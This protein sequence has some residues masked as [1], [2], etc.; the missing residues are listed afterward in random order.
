MAL[1]KRKDS[2]YWWMTLDGQG[3]TINGRHRPLKESTGIR[4]DGAS[5]EIRKRLEAQAQEVYHARMVQFARQRVGLPLDTGVTF[6]EWSRWYEDHHTNTHGGAERERVIL[7]HLRDYFGGMPLKAIRPARW[8]EYKT[9]R[10]RVGAAINTIGRELA[11]M[12][13]ILVTAVGE[14]IEVSPLAHVKRKTQRLPPKRTITAKEEQHL[15]FELSDAGALARNGGQPD[16][17]APAAERE[18]RARQEMRD[19]YLV[20]VGTLLRQMNLVQLRRSDHHH[21]RLAIDTKTEPHQVPLTG[22]T[23]LQVRAGEV[24]AARMPK[25]RDGYF[26]PEWQARFARDRNGANAKFLQAF[27]RACV[28]AG[29]PWGLKESGVVWHTATRASGA[30]RMIAE[31]RI[32]LRTVQIIGNW[33][34]LDQMAEYL[35]VDLG[36]VAARRRPRAQKT[37]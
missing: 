13:A 17:T 9:H 24:L 33:R 21:D 32:D 14:H 23:P 27:R 5:A 15:I 25:S 7:R 26:F 36:N 3:Q 22:P 37:A 10:E 34:S 28:R 16:R 29:I 31:H 1:F 18:A 4:H 11:V 12:K 2:P 8:T 20:G 6:A 19:M 35:G 30:T